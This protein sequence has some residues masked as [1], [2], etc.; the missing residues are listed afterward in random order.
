MGD[1]NKCGRCSTYHY[2]NDPCLENETEPLFYCPKCLRDAA[3]DELHDNEGYCRL[4]CE[5]NQR[6]L[7]QAIMNDKKTPKPPIDLNR[8]DIVNVREDDGS[9]SI[10]TVKYEPW[11]LGDGTWVVALRG[12]PGGFLLDRITLNRR[13]REDLGY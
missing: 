5:E 12:R 1:M 13:G 11:Q 9:V 4:C 10:Q 2:R 6:E 7:V 8:D 3:G